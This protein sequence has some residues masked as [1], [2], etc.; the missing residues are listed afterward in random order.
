MAVCLTRPVVMSPMRVKVPLVC[1][2]AAEAWLRTPDKKSARTQLELSDPLN[3]RPMGCMSPFRL[4]RVGPI[5][6]D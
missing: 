6:A 3:F 2:I 5:E 1:A 4:N